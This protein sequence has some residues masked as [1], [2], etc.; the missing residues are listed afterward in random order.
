[1]N[2]SSIPTIT[3]IIP[4]YNAQGYLDL[5]LTSLI[6]QEYPKGFIE[7]ILINNN[8]T[9]NTKCIAQGYP[10]TCLDE[11]NSQSSY[12]TRNTGIKHAKNEIIAFIDADC[13]PDPN[14][15][16]EGV[17]ELAEADAD[18]AGGRVE[19]YYSE[20]KTAAEFYDSM[21]NMQVENYICERGVAPTA[22][23]F[24]RASLFDKV[25]LFPEDA[26]SGADIRW[27]KKAT[28]MG[29]KLVYAPRAVVQHP[30][31]TFRELL[32]K[33]IRVGTGL[34]SIRRDEWGW[35]KKL[36]EAMKLILPP[37]PFAINTLIVN[38]G[39]PEMYKKFWDIW[40][41]AYLCKIAH[42]AGIASSFINSE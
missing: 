25:G 6:D 26:I 11:T 27:T 1:M 30:S 2:N 21:T 34:I 29:Y 15:L 16:R 23:L 3:V 14:W 4:A 20:R 36:I 37:N 19:F 10:I 9:D 5:L 8:S 13:L 7:I 40:V 28:S 31:R 24:V 39:T 17:A 33:H 32:A 42:C 41:V 35:P 22:N 38:R 18:I 12:V